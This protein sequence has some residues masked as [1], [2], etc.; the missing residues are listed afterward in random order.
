MIK[1]TVIIIFSIAGLISIYSGTDAGDK[2][3]HTVKILAI[4]MG[5]MF[6]L[7]A[8]WLAVTSID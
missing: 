2:G 6:V 1:L 7:S 4:V 3:E 5:Y 8:I